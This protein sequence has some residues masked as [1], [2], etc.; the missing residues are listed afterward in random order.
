MKKVLP[1]PIC[2]VVL[3]SVL[4]TGSCGDGDNQIFSLREGIGHFS[5]EYPAEYKVTR[6]DIRN[7]PT[8]Q[9]TDIG[10]RSDAAGSRSLQEIS[11]YVWPI[12]ETETAADVLGDMLSQAETIFVDYQLLAESSVMLGNIEGQE[13]SFSWNA[14]PDASSTTDEADKL[15]VISRMVCFRYNDLA[16]EIHVASDVDSQSSAEDAFQHIIDTFQVLN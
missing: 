1:L 2:L 6:I 7:E 13:A 14:F 5:M 4:F 11:V 16:W 10:L 8:S 9:Y 15:A 3:L 12:A